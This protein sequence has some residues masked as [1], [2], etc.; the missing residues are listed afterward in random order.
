MMK[1]QTNIQSNQF[2]WVGLGRRRCNALYHEIIVKVDSFWTKNTRVSPNKKDVHRQRI[3]R[4]RYQ[5][6]LRHFLE[7]TEVILLF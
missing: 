5:I 4:G 6:H 7:M 1:H 2:K 3:S